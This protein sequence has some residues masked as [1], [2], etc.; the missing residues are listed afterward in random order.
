MNRQNKPAGAQSYAEIVVNIWLEFV[1]WFI[2]IVFNVVKSKHL[3]SS[4][5]NFHSECIGSILELCADLRLMFTSAEKSAR[6]AVHNFLSAVNW[7]D[8]RL[9]EITE[10]SFLLNCLDC[11]FTLMPK[12]QQNLK[13]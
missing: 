4:P 6:A 7:D 11:K 5:I 10:I 3:N 12:L 13:F 2:I 8:L 1:S 9:I